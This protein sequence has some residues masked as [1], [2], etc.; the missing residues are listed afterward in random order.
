MIDAAMTDAN[1]D[2]SHLAPPTRQDRAHNLQQ[3]KE[4]Q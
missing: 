3:A 2:I 4:P 1:L